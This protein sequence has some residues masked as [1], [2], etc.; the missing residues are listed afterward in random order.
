M[1]D[2]VQLP[3][4]APVAAPNAVIPIPRDLTDEAYR[5]YEWSV[6]LDGKPG[7]VQCRINNPVGL[8]VGT[9]THRV[10]DA[11]GVVWCVPNVG[12]MGCILRWKP[13]PGATAVRF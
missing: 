13:K 11:D 6:V 2:R 7:R 4:P 12:H 5:E 10:I 9:T 1:N 8:V 3:P